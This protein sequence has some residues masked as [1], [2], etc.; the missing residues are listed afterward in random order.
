LIDGALNHKPVLSTIA[1]NLP[2]VI[3]SSVMLSIVYVLSPREAEKEPAG[4]RVP[5][6]ATA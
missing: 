4:L 2:H 3:L 1:L 5:P 6:P